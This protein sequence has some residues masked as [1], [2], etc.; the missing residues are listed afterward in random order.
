MTKGFSS[1]EDYVYSESPEISIGEAEGWVNKF[2]YIFPALKSRNYKLYFAGQSV[3]TIGTW[4]QIVAQGWLV[5]QLTNSAFLIGLVAAVSTLPSL[6]FSLIGG[7]VVDRFP[8]RKIL[9]A[10][11]ASAMVLAFILGILAILKI[12][13]VTEIIILS[14]LLGIVSAVD[15]PARQAFA[16][17]T[18]GK[19]DLPSAIALN[20]AIFNSARVIGPSIAGFLIVIFGTGGA[21]VLNGVSYLAIIIA[22]LFIKV[23][24]KL[25]QIHP[26][27]FEAIKEGV[28]YGLSHPIIRT[29]L[30]FTAVTSIFG[31]S[32]A[33]I[34]PVIAKNTFG[35]GAEGLG[36]LYA[37][38]G[39]GALLGTVIISGFAKKTNPLVFILGGNVL[40]IGSIV[41]FTFVKQLAFA[42]PF[43]FFA[44]MG[45]LMQFSTM[46]TTIQRLVE[47][48]YRG[49]VISLYVTT[50]MGLFPFGNFEIG[51]LTERLGSAGAIRLN[52]AIVFIFA[53]IIF[54]NRN[55]I[56]KAYL[57]FKSS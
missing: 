36:Y 22:L 11:Q 39:L 43:L 45:L 33:T 42:L 25:P 32:Y 35:L 10:T 51:F 1:E 44:G 6:F 31:W 41:G 17:E 53:L 47:D 26:H 16:V 55:K 38:S 3:S 48:K 19:E 50:F 15:A 34:M 30:I 49:R 37:A 56:Q 2:F 14:F 8:K 40:F 20:S 23:K 9:M 28:S 5:L 18:V 57:R 12:I 54:F 46:N 13:N 21:F 7:V 27:P 4:L 29:L 52:V 24:I